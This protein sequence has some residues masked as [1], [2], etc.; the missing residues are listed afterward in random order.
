MVKRNI[1]TVFGG[2][3]FLGRRVVQHLCQRELY[4]RVASRHPDRSR[5]TGIDDTYLQFMTADIRDPQSVANAIADAH[6]VVNAV[7]LYVER[8]AETFDA[9]HV[10]AAAR[11][12]AHAMKSG[13]KRLVHLSG[14]G[15]FQVA[16]HQKAW[17]RRAGGTGRVPRCGSHSSCGDVRAR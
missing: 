2:T 17:R 10:E 12:A 5:I 7:S 13:V 4:V 8:G 6:G 1:V 14:I 11:V 15:A 3:G 9:V 16:L